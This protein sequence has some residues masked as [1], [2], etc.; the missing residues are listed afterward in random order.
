MDSVA[1][2]ATVR[3]EAREESSSDMLYREGPA[4]FANGQ[5]MFS[6]V[7]SVTTPL[8]GPLQASNLRYM[9]DE[10]YRAQTDTN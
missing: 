7:Y 8:R 4:V 2:P 9:R 3:I 10:L 5:E 6:E 1:L